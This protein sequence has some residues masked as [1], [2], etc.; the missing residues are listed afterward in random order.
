MGVSP[1][2][3]RVST[4]RASVLDRFPVVPEDLS[5]QETSETLVPYYITYDLSLLFKNYDIIV[6]YDIIVSHDYD[7]I[8]RCMI[9]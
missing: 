4:S 9:S 6:A 7:I 8:A 2:P 3:A 5:V 1:M